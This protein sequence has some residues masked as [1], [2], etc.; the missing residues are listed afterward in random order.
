[1][2]HCAVSTFPL[3]LDN[4]FIGSCHNWARNRRKLT[5]RHF[6]PIVEAINLITWK[7]FEKPIINHSFSTSKAFFCRLK[8][9]VNS[10]RKISG[11]CKVLSSAKQHSGVPVMAAGMHHTLVL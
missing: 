1:M 11:L 9:Y 8:N 2:R 3:N 10:A 7:L 6:W 5:G 4:K